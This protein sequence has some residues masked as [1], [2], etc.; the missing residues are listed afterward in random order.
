MSIAVSFPSI[1]L[2]NGIP[3]HL[4]SH[5]P[6]LCAPSEAH[7]TVKCCCRW[8]SCHFYTWAITQPFPPYTITVGDHFK[9]SAKPRR[10]Q[11]ASTCHLATWGWGKTATSPLWTIPRLGCPWHRTQVSVG[12]IHTGKWLIH[13]ARL[14]V[15]VM[16]QVLQ[17]TWLLPISDNVLTIMITSWHF[18]HLLLTPGPRHSPSGPSALYGHPATKRMLSETCLF[19]GN[20]PQNRDCF[21]L[22]TQWKVL[23]N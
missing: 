2:E 7:G 17:G 4:P 3:V 9:R 8:P 10:H 13:H 5:E 16:W 19:R 22:R 6:H 12:K 15:P 20:S 11:A 21:V 23:V 18:C 14:S 1:G